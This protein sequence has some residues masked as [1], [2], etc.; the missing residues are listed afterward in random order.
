MSMVTA[1]LA[2]LKWS[3]AMGIRYAS[4]VLL[5]PD[6]IVRNRTLITTFAD[7][8]AMHGVKL[9]MLNATVII[10][11]DVLEDPNSCHR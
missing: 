6:S 9:L 5:L 1:L 7:N 4:A 3:G 8:R 2:R 10:G 11:A